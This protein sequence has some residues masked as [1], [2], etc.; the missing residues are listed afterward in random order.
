MGHIGA[1]RIFQGDQAKEGQTLIRRG[2]GKRSGLRGAGENAKAVIAEI[3]DTLVPLG[4]VLSS[5]AASPPSGRLEWPRRAL[6]PARPSPRTRKRSPCP[7]TVAIILLAVS[8][9]CFC[10]IG[11]VC[12]S[13]WAQAGQTAS[14]QQREFHRV[15]A[16]LFRRA[17]ECG[18]VA[19]DGDLQQTC[20]LRVIAECGRFGGRAVGRLHRPLRFRRTGPRSGAPSCDFRSGCRSCR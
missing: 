9:A 5:I 6:L 12:K 2:V 20:K 15:A 7:W 8:K 13:A 10:T 4:R 1:G 18:V 16:A 17:A 3:F 11:L 14:A 19:E